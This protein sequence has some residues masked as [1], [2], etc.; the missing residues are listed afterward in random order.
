MSNNLPYVQ[1]EVTPESERHW[2]DLAQGKFTVQWDTKNDV[3]VWPPKALAPWD[4]G[5]PL[6]WRTLSGAGT[7]YTFSI[8]HRGDFWAS[9]VDFTFDGPYVFGYVT[10]DDGPTVLANVVGDDA[11]EVSIGDRVRLTLPPEPVKFG[12][13]RFVRI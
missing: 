7:V 3:W 2:R 8:V 1:V 11:L 6:E 4:P 10:M 5:A 13:A 12:A 9:G